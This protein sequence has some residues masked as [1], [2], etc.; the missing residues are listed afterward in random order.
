MSVCMYVCT[1]IYTPV[2]EDWAPSVNLSSFGLHFSIYVSRILVRHLF[3]E[4]PC[5]Y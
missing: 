4:T 2:N 3:S 1:R 5:R